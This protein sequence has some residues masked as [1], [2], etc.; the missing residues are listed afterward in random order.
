MTQKKLSH[1]IYKNNHKHHQKFKKFS[2]DKH[3]KIAKLEEKQRFRK[4]SE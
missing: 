4:A 2:K 1:K 3:T